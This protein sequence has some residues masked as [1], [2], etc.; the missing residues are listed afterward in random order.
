MKLLNRNRP[1]VETVFIISAFSVLF[2]CCIAELPFTVKPDETA[3]EVGK[4]F[5]YKLPAEM[6][7]HPGY[8]FK[9]RTPDNENLPSWLEYDSTRHL[10]LG[11][12]SYHDKGSH[13]IR[14]EVIHDETNKT[15]DKINFLTIE[16]VEYE[17][18]L[19]HFKILRINTMSI[20]SKNRSQSPL[21]CSNHVP[22]IAAT[23]VFDFNSR[24][25]SGSKRVELLKSVSD[26]TS[27]D[28][29][30][31]RVLPGKGE[32]TAFNLKDVVVLTAGPGW[33]KD[34]QERGVSVSWKIGCGDSITESEKSYVS[35]G[36][37]KSAS[38]TGAF[39]DELKS[40]VVA[41]H[42]TYGRVKHRQVVRVRRQAL[43]QTPVP[44][45]A[46]VTPTSAIVTQVIGTPVM[47][48]S[49]TVFTVTPTATR[50]IPSPTQTT[51]PYTTSVPSIPPVNTP[52]TLMEPIGNLTA[53]INVPYAFRI[54]SNTFYDKEDGYTP[55]LHLDIYDPRGNP[56]VSNWL[57][58][59]PDQTL[60]GTPNALGDT[61][62]GLIVTDKK[63]LKSTLHVVT[64]TVVKKKEPPYL[65]N[66]LDV[67]RLYVGQP[68]K[69][70]LLYDQFNDKED[71]PTTKLSLDMRTA[72]DEA[73]DSLSWV[74]FDAK[75]QTIWALPREENI[76]ITEFMM[77]AYDMDRNKAIDAFQFEIYPAPVKSNHTF[78]L[79]LDAD[80]EKFKE[81]VVTRVK[82]CIEIG[83]YFGTHFNTSY[84]DIRVESYSKGSVILLWYFANIASNITGALHYKGKY[85]FSGTEDEADPAFKKQIDS[86][87][88]VSD[89]SVT[90][91][92]VNIHEPEPTTPDPNV[93]GRV[94]EDDD[95]SWWDSTIIP[96]FVVAAIIFVVGLIIIVCIRCRRQSDLDKNEK[97]VF[98][99][100]KKPAV[101][102]EEYPMREVYGNQPLITPN[103]KAPLPPPAY[104]RSSTPTE[105][106]NE[107]LL[108][109]SSPSYQPPF[110]SGHDTAGNSR[111]PVASYRLPPPY[112]AP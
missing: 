9:F 36:Q 72:D 93:V 74:S 98:V 79:E 25:L 21:D 66:H 3:T 37:L 101:F 64:I 28:V 109:D 65:Y 45:S 42:V 88:P 80:Y 91:V 10:F 111:P 7:T 55:D 22:I 59:D 46:F 39:K 75:S 49:P 31:L 104:P 38:Q 40:P 83:N 15:A 56:F 89:C 20:P 2:T 86:T 48:R 68:L 78:G 47:T 81:S 26:W 76:G 92:W 14:L 108:S 110:E 97:V 71:G 70:K 84:N 8:T 41:W 4:A 85:V 27:I 34:P 51:S 52:P 63:G 12:P 6:T 106:P 82:L 69:F 73:I 99:Q 60:R 62:I 24:K 44:T 112:V 19:N 95:G 90:K 53:E 23:L 94:D 58:V 96:L 77:I 105:D 57:R 35:V 33:V 5:S 87:C 43:A 103:E 18:D 107:R 50:I 100:R 16:V 17:E 11:V 30:Q 29:D 13:T 67:I 61:R 32:K 54:P 1:A 102:R